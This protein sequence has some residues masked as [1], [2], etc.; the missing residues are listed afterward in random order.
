MI[1]LSPDEVE[2]RFSLLGLSNRFTEPEKESLKTIPLVDPKGRIFLFPTPKDCI[3]LNLLNL[4]QILGTDPQKQPCV[5]DH[6]WY[7]TEEF[8]LQNCEPGWHGLMMDV[9]PDSIAAPL[10]YVDSRAL[11]A[12]IEVILMLFLHYLAT[13]EQLLQR[14]HSWTRDHASLGRHVTVGAFGRNGVFISGHPPEYASRGL[15]TCLKVL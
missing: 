13:H 10:N 2:R 7:L 12:A 11:P 4:R 9:M 6:P 15:G 3:G 5:F 8:G 14:K 1:S